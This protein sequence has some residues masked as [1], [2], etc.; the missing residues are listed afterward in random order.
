MMDEVAGVP[1]W[2]TVC[3]MT[4]RA[5]AL[6]GKVEIGSRAAANP[7]YERPG[8]P[9]A[10]ALRPVVEGLDN[11]EIAREVHPSP[12]T[13]TTH[14]VQILTELGARHRVRLVVMAHQGDLQQR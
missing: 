11:T 10:G 13:A 14:V 9:G 8:A 12:P 1:S 2:V 5:G 6:R 3:G 4:E 7:G